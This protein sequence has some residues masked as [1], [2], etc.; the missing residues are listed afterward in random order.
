MKKL[1]IL[2]LAAVLTFSLAGTAFAFTG[3]TTPE[4]SNPNDT[5]YTVDIQLVDYQTASWGDGYYYSVS[6]GRAYVINEVVGA[7]VK[8][9]APADAPSGVAT[10]QISGSNMKLIE[11]L[12]EDSAA[13]TLDSNKLTREL[14]DHA[15]NSSK[16]TYKFF[17][18]AQLTSASGGTLTAKVIDGDDATSGITTENGINVSGRSGE[19]FNVTLDGRNYRIEALTD[20]EDIVTGDYLEITVDRNY[21]GESMFVSDGE[22]EYQL[23]TV[24]GDIAFKSGSNYVVDGDD[25]Y[26]TLYDR[27]AEFAYE[28][29]LDF[30]KSGYLYPSFF[31][32]DSFT[33]SDTANVNPA[34]PSSALRPDGS[35]TIPQTGSVSMIGFGLLALSAMAAVAFRKA[36][37]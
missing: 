13:L 33:V 30:T 22:G 34:L 32:G 20:G 4:A 36:R 29:R 27:Y 11:G 19:L 35:V 37:S 16:T 3:I 24:N 23:V 14:G 9:T 17:V 2:A 8:V 21:R 12:D 25:A 18:K 1:L 28:F 10:L 15:G 7:V 26:D 5:A 6:A 31:T